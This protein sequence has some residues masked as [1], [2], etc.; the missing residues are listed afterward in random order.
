MSA[1]QPVTPANTSA[2][3]RSW[4][5]FAMSS[6]CTW[7][8]IPRF[9]WSMAATTSAASRGPNPRGF[10]P[11]TSGGRP[12]PP[13]KPASVSRALARA[14]SNGIAG[15]GPVFPGKPGGRTPLAASYSPW[16]AVRAICGRLIACATAWRTRMSL[17]GA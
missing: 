10:G 3:R 5:H 15:S 2:F 7:T 13:G 1:V 9:S 16:S 6:T 8:C 14:G 11:S 4:R 12:F 17:N